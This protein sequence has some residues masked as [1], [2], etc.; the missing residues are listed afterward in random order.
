MIAVVIPLLLGA[1]T[2]AW[3]GGSGQAF[4]GRIPFRR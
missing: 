1:A 4:R 3:F 2:E